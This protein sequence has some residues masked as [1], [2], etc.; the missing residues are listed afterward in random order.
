MSVG[1][2]VSIVQVMLGLVVV[3]VAGGSAPVIALASSGSL[4]GA[5]REGFDWLRER[6]AKRQWEEESSKMQWRF[7]PGPGA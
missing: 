1:R 4:I 2:V 3:V 5:G 6:R 7:V